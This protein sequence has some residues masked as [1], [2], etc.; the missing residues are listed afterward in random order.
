MGKRDPRVDAYI[1][2]SPEF[3]KPILEYVRETAHAAVP[4]I[5]ETMKWSTPFF[6]YK[7]PVAMIAAFKEHLRFGFW[8]GSAVGLRAIER[9]TSMKDLPPKRE[10]VS[11]FRKAAELNEKGVKAVRAAKSPKKAPRT[12]PD[13]ASALKKNR[14]AAAVWEGFA[15]SHRRE[16]IDWITGAKA[17]DTRK[18]RLDQAI[19]WIGEGKQRNWKYK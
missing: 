1:A 5:E 4:D 13:L 9:V 10:L 17:G 3:A 19:E 7:G 15:P 12:P 11:L 14:K 6:E 16:Y 8:K 2:K 18:R